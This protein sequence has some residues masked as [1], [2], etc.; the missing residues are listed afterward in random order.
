M[1]GRWYNRHTLKNKTNSVFVLLTLCSYCS[2]PDLEWHHLAA[3]LVCRL[4]FVF[5]DTDGAR[6][7]V[8]T[9]VS[10]DGDDGSVDFFFPLDAKTSLFVCLQLCFSV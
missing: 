6:Q 7:A 3:R 4:F 5:S 9:C 2:F 1:N 10:T 8:K